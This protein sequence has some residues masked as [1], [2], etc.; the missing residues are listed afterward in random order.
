MFRSFSTKNASDS[1]M[2]RMASDDL[3]LDAPNQFY[4]MFP[5]IY[6]IWFSLQATKETKKP[7]ETS[8]TTTE[9]P[10]AI[11]NISRFLVNFIYLTYCSRLREIYC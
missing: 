11:K 6:M 5:N 1:F 2:S 3:D 4:V 10:L 7:I 9:M 8:I